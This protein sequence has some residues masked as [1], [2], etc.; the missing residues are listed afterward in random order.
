M[1]LHEVF[2]STVPKENREGNVAYTQISVG[3]TDIEIYSVYND[4]E[5]ELPRGLFAIPQVLYQQQLA[6]EIYQQFLYDVTQGVEKLFR[7]L[8]LPEKST[9]ALYDTE[10]EDKYG[11]RI[12]EIVEVIRND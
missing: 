2:R 10:K 3:E 8:G 7:Q 9:V 4:P 1:G 6:G 5:G 12:Y 11:M